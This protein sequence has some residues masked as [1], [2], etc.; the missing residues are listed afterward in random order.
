MI[1]ADK[2]KERGISKKGIPERSM[3]SILVKVTMLFFLPNKSKGA[4]KITI[5]MEKYLKLKKNLK[6]K[7]T[8]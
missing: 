6:I 2:E 4:R 3:T 7:K 8:V 5:V 1:E